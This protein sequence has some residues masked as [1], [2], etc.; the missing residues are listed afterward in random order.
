M[1]IHFVTTS[2]RLAYCLRAGSLSIKNHL[3]WPFTPLFI[4]TGGCLSVRSYKSDGGQDW[5]S[6]YIKVHSF[7]YLFI[8]HYFINEERCTC[9]NLTLCRLNRVMTDFYRLNLTG[10]YGA[11][12]EGRRHP[13]RVAQSWCFIISFQLRPSM[14]HCVH[15]A[16]SRHMSSLQSSMLKN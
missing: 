1:G 13:Q 16:G 15:E 12:P 3:V 9:W 7:I 14:P 10:W 2:T 11:A 8:S 4:L 5:L 6:C